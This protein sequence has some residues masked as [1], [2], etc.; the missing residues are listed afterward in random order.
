MNDEI[1]LLRKA[2]EQSQNASANVWDFARD[3]PTHIKD[4]AVIANAQ[5]S[6]ALRVTSG[7]L[8][9]GYDLDDSQHGKIFV[10][11]Q[12]R[13]ILNEKGHARYFYDEFAARK[14]CWQHHMGRAESEVQA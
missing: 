1:K 10:L 3:L 5:A 7:K 8:P 11:F 6:F 9:P 13:D 4:Q 2:L 14:F 12:D